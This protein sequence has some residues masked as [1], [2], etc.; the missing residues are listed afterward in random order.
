MTLA[1]TELENANVALFFNSD[2]VSTSVEAA[3]V[4]ASLDDM[5]HTSSEFTKISAGGLAEALADADALVLPHI[6]IRPLD[7]KNSAE[8]VVRD[9]VASGHTLILTRGSQSYTVDFLKD[10]FGFELSVADG[11]TEAAFDL[12]AEADG[13]VFAGGT[14]PLTANPASATLAR[15]SL[16]ADSLTIYGNADESLVAVM[17]FGAGQIVFLGWDWFNAE[18]NGTKDGGWLDV[19]DNAISSPDGF[20]ADID[21]NN[22]NNVING[23]RS[24][25][26]EPIATIRRDDISGKGG[27]DRISALAGDDDL[28]G[29]G[30]D[31]KLNGG[32]GLDDVIGGKGQDRLTGGADNDRF[33]YLEALKAANRDSIVDFGEGDDGIVVNFAAL[34]ETVEVGEL[35]FG[36]KADEANAQLIYDQTSGKLWFDS[37]GT[38]KAGQ[39]WFLTLLNKAELTFEDFIIPP[40]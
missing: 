7:L 25:G 16:P 23:R 21:G 28:A 8:E 31:D 40:S 19:L 1:A 18:P 5:G 20:G 9:F 32:A 15:S 13:T 3:N 17:G 12:D 27:D 38:G 30:G 11:D 10:V 34:G 37:D 35:A 2:Y 6:L 24:I 39:V 22:A 26:D 36:A 29:D 4:A 14:D 33:F